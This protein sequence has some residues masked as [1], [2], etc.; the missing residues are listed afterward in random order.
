MLMSH[1]PSCGLPGKCRCTLVQLA[2]PMTARH[3]ISLMW[4]EKM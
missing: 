4:L 1:R 2:C 3:L